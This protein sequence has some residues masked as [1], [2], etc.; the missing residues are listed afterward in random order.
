MN[1]NHAEQQLLK[2]SWPNSHLIALAR[3]GFA[4]SNANTF[5]ANVFNGCMPTAYSFE[6]TQVVFRQRMSTNTESF[7]EWLVLI[8]RDDAFGSPLPLLF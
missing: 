5:S 2:L 8:A 1:R 4:V 3:F 6:N 7:T